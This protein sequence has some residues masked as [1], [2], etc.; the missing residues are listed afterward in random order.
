MRRTNLSFS[1]TQGSIN[2]RNQPKCMEKCKRENHL[3][4]CSRAENLSRKS[5]WCGHTLEGVSAVEVWSQASSSAAAGEAPRRAAQ[6][7]W[8]VQEV[9]LVWCWARPSQVRGLGTGNQQS[10]EGQVS[11]QDQGQAPAST[12][13]ELVRAWARPQQ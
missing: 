3:W 8:S 1:L 4:R 2:H 13:T 9:V 7:A 5:V 12:V 10:R 6:L 11:C